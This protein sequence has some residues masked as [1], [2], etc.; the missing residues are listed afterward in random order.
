MT[1][2]PLALQAVVVAALKRFGDD[3][4]LLPVEIPKDL[5]VAPCLQSW[6]VP[7]GHTGELQTCNNDVTCCNLCIQTLMM[8]MFTV[9]L[10]APTA[11]RYFLQDLGGSTSIPTETSRAF[12]GKHVQQWYLRSCCML[13]TETCL[14]FSIP[15]RECLFLRDILWKMLVTG[16]LR[17][18]VT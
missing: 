1:S 10:V 4:H 11:R 5:R 16:P 9:E 6:W 8:S 12:G 14:Q 2:V 7:A 18:T 17:C 13:S 3:V 15:R